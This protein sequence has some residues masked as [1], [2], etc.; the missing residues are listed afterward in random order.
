MLTV[1]ESNKNNSFSDIEALEAFLMHFQALPKE[2]A[3]KLKDFRITIEPLSEIPP[4]PIELE[5]SPCS[6][7]SFGLWFFLAAM[8]LYCFNWAINALKNPY[9]PHHPSV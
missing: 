3:E 8:S 9:Y 2:Q 1:V 5:R 4:R 6:V 7:C